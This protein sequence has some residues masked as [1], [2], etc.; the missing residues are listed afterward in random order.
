[1]YDTYVQQHL[2]Y[3]SLHR[4]KHITAVC[5]DGVYQNM[6]SVAM[7]RA[8][9]LKIWARRYKHRYQ[10]VYSSVVYAYTYQSHYI[11]EPFGVCSVC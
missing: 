6:N 2:V 7:T 9:S 5:M 11:F 10:P 1:M 4:T 8:A 3:S